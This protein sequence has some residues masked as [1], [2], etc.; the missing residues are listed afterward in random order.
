MPTPSVYCPM[1]QKVQM[2]EWGHPLT[3][4]EPIRRVAPYAEVTVHGDES[5]MELARLVVEHLDELSARAI[6]ML[7]SFMRDSGKYDLVFIEVLAGKTDDGCDFSLEFQ[8]VAD[9]DP[10]EYGYT[11]FTV[12]FAHRKPPQEIFW[13][14]KMIIG[15]M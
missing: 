5:R 1:C 3:Q 9:R 6:K 13:P 14:H 8:F 2:T 10:N 12:Y 11:Y 15:F 4:S 7:E